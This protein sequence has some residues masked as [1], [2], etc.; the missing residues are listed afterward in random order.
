ME[1]KIIPIEL[2]VFDFDG[3][4]VQSD[5]DLARAVNHALE[6]IGAPVRK[7]EEIRRFIGD[8]VE[9]L[10]ER[11]LGP[12]RKDMFPRALELFLDYYEGHLLDTTTLYPGVRETLEY[13]RH[14]R[15]MIVTNK[16]DAFTQ[17]IASELGITHYFDIILGRDS[18]PYAKPDPRIL[19]PW[20]ERF[21]ARRQRTVVVGDGVNDIIFA[22]NAGV[23]SCALLNGLTEREELIFLGPDYCCEQIGEL[24]DYFR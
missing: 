23:L 12:E 15:K 19:L 13:F 5:R 1:K 14:V 18:V 24:R 17:T 20:M 11:A 22:K 7:E 2:M 8:G 3:T 4:L 6:S 9:K 10:I 16:T 21:G